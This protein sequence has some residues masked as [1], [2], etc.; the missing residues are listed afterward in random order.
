MTTTPDPQTAGLFRLHHVHGH[1]PPQ[2]AT[3]MIAR[4]LEGLDRSPPGAAGPRLAL[5]ASLVRQSLVFNPLDPSLWT[6]AQALAAHVPPGP[7]FAAWTRQ[8]RE[9][10]AAAPPAP[11][12]AQADLDA[13][14]RLAED[15]E[16]DGLAGLA[17]AHPVPLV[18]FLALVQLWQ[19]GDRDRLF[20]LAGQVLAQPPLGLTAPFF[21]W[22][23][24]AA[25]LA[26]MAAR[27]AALGPESFLTL[28]LAAE[29][30]LAAGDR[31]EARRLF[32]ASLAF[33]P[34]QSFLLLK[35][36]GLDRPAPDLRL[37]ERSR[38]AVAFYTYNKL[39]LTLD[40]LGS[41]L[42]SDIGPASV[43]LL[44]NGSTAFSRED[45]DAGVRATARGRAVEVVHLPVNVG[46]PAARNWLWS[47][48]SSCRADFV[49]Y[50][51]DDVLLPRHWL[52][53]FLQDLAEDPGAAVVG[54]KILNP[55][56]LPTVQYGWR[57]FLKTGP[58]LIR[59]TDN[60]PLVMD[61]GQY[62]LSRPCLSVM[63]CCH[64]FNRRLCERLGLPGFDVRFTPSQVDD[65]E[66]D[67]QVW[68]A[69][70]RVLYDG[71]AAVTHVRGS[72]PKG[73]QSL[74]LQGHVWGNH[75]KMEHKFEEKELADMDAAV[76]AADTGHLAR[77][78]AG[79]WDGLAQ[80]VRDYY[81]LF[82]DLA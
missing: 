58:G 1:S 51:D 9:V 61:L 22:A 64:L 78:V 21:A 26:D 11:A 43:A 18:R 24:R 79:A 54:P 31:E 76:T 45:L 39:T 60:A 50:L 82:L 2:R 75:M 37:P 19:L 13:V 74:A 25:G 30:A 17:R 59:F 36:A 71:R 46:A 41:L 12:P 56:P 47:L 52:A 70:A 27:L 67:L 62:D 29:Q 72:G 44:N 80:P 3:W 15:G 77:A 34:G 6:Q 16:A 68:K 8:A 7:G 23:A 69:G 38:V 20:P 32:L 42:D 49:A 81:R 66:H 48:P 33:E 14:G 5:A 10:L 57:F 73:L 4:L 55:T 65:I 53:A 35:L 63:G 28:N 40:T